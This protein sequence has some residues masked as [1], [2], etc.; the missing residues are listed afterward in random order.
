MNTF[1]ITLKNGKE[2]IVKAETIE[3]QSRD[4]GTCKGILIDGMDLE[5]THLIFIDYNEIVSVE[6]HPSV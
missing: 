3:A 2:I 5:D 6:R 4:N 1:Y